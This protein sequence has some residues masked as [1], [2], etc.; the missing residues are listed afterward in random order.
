M[1]FILITQTIIEMINGEYKILVKLVK[2]KE[3]FAG[4]SSLYI[5][6]KYIYIKI[7][8]LI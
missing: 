8:C 6:S 1:D 2:T 3:T 5:I 7:K 4:F